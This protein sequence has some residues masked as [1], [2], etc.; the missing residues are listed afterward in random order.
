MTETETKVTD[1]LVLK[2]LHTELGNKGIHST[3]GWDS[4]K[5]LVSIT[6]DKRS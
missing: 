3:D 2:T 4:Q 1:C 6:S 5:E